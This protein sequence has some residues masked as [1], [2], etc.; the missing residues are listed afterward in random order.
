VRDWATASTSES[1]LLTGAWYDTPANH[2]L[3]AEPATGLRRGDH[4]SFS[5]DIAESTV[6]FEGDTNAVD[7]APPVPAV[8][9]Q[10]IS[11]HSSMDGLKKLELVAY[12][13]KIDY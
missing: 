5:V 11:D 7:R 9:V 2:K 10:D 13:G 3:W 1:A 6:E 8:F 12:D 4:F